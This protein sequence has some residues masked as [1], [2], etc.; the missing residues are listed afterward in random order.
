MTDVWIITLS[1]LAVFLAIIAILCG[2]LL[3]LFNYKSEIDDCCPS[4]ITTFSSEKIID[5]VKDYVDMK[6]NKLDEKI[7]NL[8]NSMNLISTRLIILENSATFNNINQN[9]LQTNI[10]ILNDL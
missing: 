1:V 3:P 9:A 4:S 8:M 5:F 10:N 7:D 2:T 6:F